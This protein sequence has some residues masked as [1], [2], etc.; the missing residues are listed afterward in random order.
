MK[1]HT[2]KETSYAKLQCTMLTQVNIEPVSRD[3][4]SGIDG[5]SARF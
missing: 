5:G 2:R 1:K 4:G 3:T